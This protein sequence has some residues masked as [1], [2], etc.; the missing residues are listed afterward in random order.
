MNS[1]LQCLANSPELTKFFLLGIYKRQINKENP[2]G[3]GGQLATAYAALVSEMW[4]GSNSKT[5]PY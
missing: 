5:A 3:M 2:L 4:Y 1:G